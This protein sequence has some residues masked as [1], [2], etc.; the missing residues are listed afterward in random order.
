[1]T[2]FINKERIFANATKLAEILLESESYA[3]FYE[4]LSKRDIEYN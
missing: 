1:M 2:D 3:D 4:R